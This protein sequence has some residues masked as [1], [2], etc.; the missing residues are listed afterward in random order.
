MRQEEIQSS[1]IVTTGN[2]KR[3]KAAVTPSEADEMRTY[4]GGKDGK[5]QEQRDDGEHA[6]KWAVLAIVAVGVFMATLDSSIVNISLPTIAHSFGVPLSGA[7]EWV[8]IAYLVITAA[9]LMTAGRVADMIGRKPIWA[10]GLIVFTLGSALCGAA[11]TLGFLI[12][13]R[14]LQG[15]GGALIMSISPAML[16]RAFAASERGRALG[17]N[18][19]V[20][21][22]GVS[23]GP[24]LG[25]I[26]TANLSWRWIF[27]VNLPIGIVGVIATLLVL[28]ER[29]HRGEGKF[30]PL[31][32]LLLGIGLATLTLGVSFGQEWGW[33][34]PLL[35]STLAVSVVAFCFLVVVER[36][37]AHPII[38][39]SLLRRRVFLSANTSLILSFLA[40]FAVSFM[41]PFYLEELRGFPTEVA[42]LLLTPLPLTI[43]VFAPFSGALADRIGTRWLAA[44]GL[45]LACI[46]LVLISQLNAQS[47]V[48]DIVWRLVV[49]G[50]GQAWFQSPNN[51][52]LMGAA[53]KEL[54][55]AASGFLA[56]GRVVGQSLS[57][58][59]AGAVFTSLGGAMAGQLLVAH[60]GRLSAEQV[61]SLQQ[62]FANS[63][64]VTFV[65]CAVIA[66]VGIFMSLVRGNEQA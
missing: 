49:T 58:A 8:I 34:S 16:T 20:V 23:T 57:V 59:L 33:T 7:V 53:P 50:L 12:A 60:A 30:D 62:T 10:G 41:L 5:P 27:F 14:A 6:G 46:G 18:A 65:V 48:W 9:V 36:R 3:A 17:L 52:A 11:P 24:T 66:A 55:G 37:V 63:F 45:T 22:L 25:G 38:A 31:G 44:G 1:N 21:A 28:T 40:L 2:I 29:L 4:E 15:L 43:A 56:T 39:F 26:I 47:S 42:G 51:S 64:H 19:V 61:I 32:A 13:A 35:L 54:Q